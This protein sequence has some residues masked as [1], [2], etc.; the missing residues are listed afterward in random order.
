M[1]RQGVRVD[2]ERATTSAVAIDK[3][4]AV[5]Q[6]ELDKGAG[7]TVNV[8][9]TKQMR[10]MLNPEK[11]EDG[12]WRVGGVLLE[13][14]GTGAP[15][16]DADA[17]RSLTAVGNPHAANA[18]RIR[19]LIKGK[20]FLKDH[21]LGHEVNG[22]VYPN[23]N[24]TRGENGMGTGTGRFSIDDPALQQIPARD[25][26]VAEIARS[27]FIPDY[28]HEWACFDFKQFEQRLFAHYAKDESVY[29]IYRKN[30]DADFYQVMADLSGLPRN[31]TYAG[32][33]NAKQMTLAAIFGMGQG[34][35]AMEMGLGYTV[36]KGRNGKE[37]LK[38]GQEATEALNKFYTAVPGIRG[39]LDLASSIA[40]SRG[41]IKTVLGRRLRFPD[42]QFTHKAGGLV[43]QGSAADSLKLKMI[44]MDKL[45]KGT[46]I[47]MLLSVH[48]EI[49]MDVPPEAKGLVAD[50]V[51]MY[52]T[53]DGVEAPLFRVPIMCS[54]VLAEN[55][56]E[57]SR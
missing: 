21:I 51:K 12:R 48:D 22:V 4:V 18:L 16:L 29:E 54:A 55:W 3:L 38:P 8:N 14:T 25:V 10:E 49:D 31:P 44:Q 43:L 9:S 11:G 41:Y 39:H 28:G 13:S 46:G 15:S 56:F 19:K 23:Y 30:P 36:E 35:L 57:A 24:Q 17:L 53:F 20:S 26:E 6:K 45:I 33:A 27:C 1:E 40:K 37:W 2:V 5:A 50:M 47:K 32:Q 52:S 34:R 7:R 42:G